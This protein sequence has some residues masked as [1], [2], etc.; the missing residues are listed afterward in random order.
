MEERE[1][2][3]LLD[4]IDRRIERGHST[5]PDVGSLEVLHGGLV[6]A[7]SSEFAG[8][9]TL[10]PE[11][12]FDE[13]PLLKAY[14]SGWEL[15]DARVLILSNAYNPSAA[16]TSYVAGTGNRPL[17]DPGVFST[18]TAAVFSSG[19]KAS[20]FPGYAD[21]DIP[22]YLVQASTTNGTSF[23][24]VDAYDDGLPMSGEFSK[25][26]VVWPVKTSLTEFATSF[27][28]IKTV[29]SRQIEEG[30]VYGL[31]LNIKP[32][33]AY[34]D[35]TEWMDVTV[36]TQ[37]V[38]SFSD[39]N[40]RTED[41]NPYIY[42]SSVDGI[43][44]HAEINLLFYDKDGGLIGIY[45]ETLPLADTGGWISPY[46][47]FI[48]P[49]GTSTMGIQ[50]L[51]TTEDESTPH[52]IALSQV[53]LYSLGTAESIP[54]LD[55]ITEKLLVDTGMVVDDN[56]TPDPPT[57]LQLSTE[58]VA[59]TSPGLSSTAKITV[60]WD[61]PTT[62]TDGTAIS[63][64]AGT[65]IRLRYQGATEFLREVGISS[66]EDSF[67][68]VDVPLS[69]NFTVSL[70][71]YNTHN[72]YS[73]VVEDNI[74]TTT[75]A[76]PANVNPVTISSPGANFVKVAFDNNEEYSVIAYEVEY[77]TSDT[78]SF[79]GVW[80]LGG[81]CEALS[82]VARV[83]YTFS[84]PG[85]KKYVRAR[86]YAVDVLGQK[87]ATPT[88]CTVPAGYILLTGIDRTEFNTNTI[89]DE[90]NAI[91][92]GGGVTIMDGT[93][94]TC[95]NGKFLIHSSN[96]TGATTSFTRMTSNG[97][98]TA[99]ASGNVAQL[100]YNNEGFYGLYIEKGMVQINCGT[101]TSNSVVIDST[102]IHSTVSGSPAF[103]LTNT[104]GLTIYKGNI[105]VSNG[106]YVA[107]VGSNG[108]T[109]GNAMYL[110]ATDGL[111]VVSSGVTKV[112]INTSG[113]TLTD[114]TINTPTLWVK[115]ST[116]SNSIKMTSADGIQVFD[117]GGT[118]TVLITSTGI[119]L[120]NSANFSVSL[121]SPTI[122]GGL[123]RTGTGNHR[124]EISDEGG[125]E[126]I[127]FYAGN[128][129]YANMGIDDTSAHLRLTSVSPG[130]PS[131]NGALLVI[132]QSTIAYGSQR[133]VAALE[134]FGLL[135]SSDVVTWTKQTV[136]ANG[137]TATA[138]SSANITSGWQTLSM[139]GISYIPVGTV[140]NGDR[141][142]VTGMMRGSV[143]A[144][145]AAV[146][147][148]STAGSELARF[149]SV[150][151]AAGDTA[152]MGGM[153]EAGSDYDDIRIY[154]RT[155]FSA[156]STNQVLAGTSPERFTCMTVEVLR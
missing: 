107:V 96:D 19:F 97:I 86:V 156:G 112:S 109:T 74:S 83:E 56:K 153:W 13:Y 148:Y 130:V 137:Q 40:Y 50:F 42:F 80:T 24:E 93:G 87:S 135:D 121:E 142:F 134:R 17:T 116:T 65:R 103:D 62:N 73:E 77:E 66:G 16:G 69:R 129:L 102:G 81:R 57:N 21:S 8:L 14:L 136:Y 72:R 133:G 38:V 71:A 6:P 31:Q 101:S 27:S 110:N 63:D 60:T 54:E 119:T 43:A 47:K 114:A 25:A 68:L 95:K 128:T 98:T 117:S 2:D 127:R 125:F 89:R 140:K 124:V 132:P 61:E 26:L 3:Q 30:K 32:F 123:Y 64:Y 23:T 12:N 120:S 41:D 155:N 1:I 20:Y 139:T 11:N 152:F 92:T 4:Y 52:G 55:M 49:D 126:D 53:H 37:P 7:S 144:Y 51:V 149:S 141:V 99:D 115:G 91:E 59:A 10:T 36:P 29:T 111:K 104:G 146:C 85:Y 94:I 35:E 108:Q 151:Q 76:V 44:A 34:L 138:N 45:D 131:Y 18:D 106:G 70:E 105:T 100:G 88:V 143:N 46:W 122:T 90:V 145:T 33:K 118:N 5:L 58:L 75:M 39:V 67:V 113:I 150:G 154:L 79:A 15:D 147:V 78:T 9:K 22:L 28:M 84:V 82:N 48:T